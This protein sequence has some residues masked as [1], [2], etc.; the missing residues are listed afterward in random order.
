[1]VI[2]I[3]SWLVA[4]SESGEKRLGGLL[5]LLGEKHGVDV[6]ENTA[7]SDGD[8]AEELVELFVGE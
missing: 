2:R 1:V 5:G 4:V 3:T 6:G 7:G 8:T